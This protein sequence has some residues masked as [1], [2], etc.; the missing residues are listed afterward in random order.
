[1]PELTFSPHERARSR[2]ILSVPDGAHNGHGNRTLIMH[3]AGTW[4]FTVHTWLKESVI[5][6]VGKGKKLFHRVSLRESAP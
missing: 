4:R 3:V 1:M 5:G 6:I 2:S